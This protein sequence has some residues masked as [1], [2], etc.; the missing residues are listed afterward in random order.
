[1]RLFFIIPCCAV[2]AVLGYDGP[3]PLTEV[4]G[5][6]PSAWAGRC[7]AA[8]VPIMSTGEKRWGDSLEGQ[9]S[10]GA[11]LSDSWAVSGEL[12]AIRNWQ[13]RHFSQ[14][15]LH[16]EVQYYLADECTAGFLSTDSGMIPA[17]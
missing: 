4:D 8:T 11:S 15:T 9:I 5:R 16:G 6:S 13:R 10:G 2:Q 7:L 12:F 14:T 17:L 1:M 3:P